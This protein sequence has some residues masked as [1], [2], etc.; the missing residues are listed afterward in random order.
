MTA[1]RRFISSFPTRG[2]R[3]AITSGASCSRKTQRSW[4]ASLRPVGSCMPRPTGPTM[5]SRCNK[6][7]PPSRCSSRWRAALP[8]GRRRSS[9]RVERDWGTRFAT[10]IFAAD[11]NR[12]QLVEEEPPALGRAHALP[13]A[14]DETAPLRVFQLTHHGDKRKAGALL[15]ERDR[16]TLDEAQGV[17]HEFERQ[18][19]RRHAGFTRER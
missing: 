19:G 18:L 3:R 5:Q 8:P 2:L 14:L 1:S 15:E 17:Q 4:R 10:C 11:K 6:Y 12:Q 13:V 7:S 16:K 9:R